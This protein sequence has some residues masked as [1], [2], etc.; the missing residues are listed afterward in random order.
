MGPRRDLPPRGAAAWWIADKALRRMG[1]ALAFAQEGEDRL[2]ERL[3]EGEPPGVFVD[4]GAH[5]PVRFSNTMSLY[6]RGWRGLSIDPRPGVEPRFGRIRR[7]D[8]F[9]AVGVAT[10]SGDSEYFEFDEPALNTFSPEIARQRLE[11]TSYRLVRRSRMP[12]RRLDDLLRSHLPPGRFDLLNVDVEGRD[13][14]VLLSNDWETF[15]PRLVC[16]EE[17]GDSVT[18]P[19]EDHLARWGYE[20]LARTMNS[21]VFRRVH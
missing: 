8:R 7:Y 17:L 16:C 3:L 12:T 2:L 19:V 5:D 9:L 1:A 20:P 21:R 13:L 14:D 10:D 11:E 15:R 6:L 4:V 18:E